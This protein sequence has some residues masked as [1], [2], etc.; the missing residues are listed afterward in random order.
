MDKGTQHD[1]E[2]YDAQSLT[3]EATLETES[4]TSSKDLDSS[5]YM[6][7]QSEGKRFENENDADDYC[8]SRINAP[9]AIVVYW[10]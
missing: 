5:F 8:N 1:I 10:S 3:E 2:N 6:S 7:S 4:D 9:S